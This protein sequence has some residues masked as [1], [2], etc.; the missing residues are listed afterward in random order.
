[1]FSGLAHGG[2]QIEKITRQ[3]QTIHLTIACP[4]HFIAGTQIGDSIAVDGTC[5]TVEQ[6]K[7]DTFSTTLMPQTF[8]KTI[9][10]NRQAGEA[11]N[12]ERSLQVGDRLEGHLV[13]GHIDDVAQLIQK[14]INENAIELRFSFPVSL[15]K[16]IIPQGSVALNGV[17]L[18]VMNTKDNSFT[19][20]LIPHT[21]KETN[22]SQLHI[23]DFVNLE[24][25]ILG[26]YVA[27]NALVQE[28]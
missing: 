12:L 11:V 17:S 2:A 27:Q 23:G 25:D 16:Q 15:E 24:T 6:V 21:Q 13:T 8:K 26:K 4:S 1:M 14:R 19:V 7:G 28:V 22:L 3:G 10:K 18:T 20:G 9:F 5:L